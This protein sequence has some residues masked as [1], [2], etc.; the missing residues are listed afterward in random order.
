MSIAPQNPVEFYQLGATVALD[1]VGEAA[2]T[3]CAVFPAFFRDRIEPVL[4]CQMAALHQFR[5][6]LGK[7]KVANAVIA[8]RQ[9]RQCRK[10]DGRRD[11]GHKIEDQKFNVQLVV[12]KA[13]AS[14]LGTPFQ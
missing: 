13:V 14:H 8:D 2:L 12:D 10:V 3:G 1:R 6:R 7:L 5:N 4:Q 9:L 11:P